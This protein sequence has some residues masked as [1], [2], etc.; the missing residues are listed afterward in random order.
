MKSIPPPPK[1]RSDKKIY[2]GFVH[3]STYNESKEWYTP[4]YIFDALGLEF[5]LDPCSPGANIVPWIPVKYHLTPNDNGLDT[6]WQGRVWMNPPYGSDTPKWM[7][8]L[9]TAGNGIALVFARTDTR[10]FHTYVPKS[11]AI[12]FIKGRVQFIRA[13][14]ALK[15]SQGN[16]KPQGGCGAGS[17]LIAYGKENAN[18]L[19]KS[20]LGLV[21]NPTCN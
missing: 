12:C 10:W 20:K 21:L 7:Q 14:E 18:A 19:I 8:R 15:Y 11:D 16:Y 13:T 1:K 3:E 17:M 6:H 4:K 9:S 2:S 5:D